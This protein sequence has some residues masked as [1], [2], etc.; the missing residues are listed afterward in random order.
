MKAEDAFQ[1]LFALGHETLENLQVQGAELFSKSDFE[2]VPMVAE[3][4]QK[5]SS[6]ISDL[7]ILRTR[8][9]ECLPEPVEIAHYK[10]PIQKTPDGQITIQANYRI[11]ILQALM[12][13]TG[14]GATSIVIDRV[15]GIMKDILSDVDNQL[16]PSGRDIRWRNNCAWHRYSMVQDGLLKKDSKMGIW[17]ISSEG[18]DYYKKVTES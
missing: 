12:E 2:G 5:V 10:I 9:M 4:A 17:E 1:A 16:L 3:Q 15:G 11:P 7:Q 8:W 13:M 14:K 18:I 6:I